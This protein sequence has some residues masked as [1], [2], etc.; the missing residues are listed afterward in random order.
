MGDTIEGG[1][2][3]QALHVGSRTVPQCSLEVAVLPFLPGRLAV[4]SALPFALLGLRMFCVQLLFSAFW[5]PCVQ[6]AFL[7]SCSEQASMCTVSVPFRPT[8]SVG[9]SGGWRAALGL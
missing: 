8:L 5:P 3:Y 1:R 4:Y 9:F 7:L 2:V 6:S